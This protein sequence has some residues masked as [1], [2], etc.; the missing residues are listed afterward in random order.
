MFTLSNRGKFQLALSCT[1][2]VASFQECNDVLGHEYV[3]PIFLRFDPVNDTLFAVV[4]VIPR[5]SAVGEYAHIAG[6][7]LERYAVHG[8]CL[9]DCQRPPNVGRYNNLNICPRQ[10]FR[11]GVIR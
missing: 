4:A 9:Y 8:S 2:P 6:L 3:K 7:E 5:L 11:H 1:K 10:D